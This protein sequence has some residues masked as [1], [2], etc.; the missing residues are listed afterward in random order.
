[1]SKRK[2]NNGKSWFGFFKRDDNKKTASLTPRSRKKK[3]PP[4]IL[5]WLWVMLT[6]VGFALLG[7]GLTAG[8]MV[9]ENYVKG[10]PQ[11][12][13]RSGALKLV[14][15]PIWLEQAWLDE[16]IKTAGG[17][18][19]V[20]DEDAAKAI[21]ERLGRIP[22]MTDIRVQTTPEN[23]VIHAQYRRPIVQ[24]AGG[25]DKYYY[26]DEKMV[27]FDALPVTKIAV[28]EVVGFTQRSIPSAGSVMLADDV[29]AAVDLVY[30]L[31]LMDL[32]MMS[33]EK[34]IQK[35]L[36]DEIASV[37]VSNFAGRKNAAQPHLILNVKD[38]VTQVY[39]GAAMGQAARYLE[40]NEKEKVTSLYQ[41]YTEYGNTLKGKGKFIELRQPQT[42]ILRPQ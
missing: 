16:I 41:H 7:A 27:L 14:N 29:K 17:I 10:L 21:A 28:P 6:I 42:L 22:W 18:R 30:V 26:L 9:M 35:P 38:G 1:M 31:S 19:F 33:I 5:S 32:Q 39:W 37:D 25:K 40:A 36:L 24:V 13:Q 15:P 4:R 23:I 12:Q 3:E 2:K 20:L 34:P 8:F 11:T